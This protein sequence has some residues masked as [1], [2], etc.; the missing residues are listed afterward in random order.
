MTLIFITI[1]LLTID[2]DILLLLIPNLT[3]YIWKISVESL[4]C[5]IRS[6]GA[7]YDYSEPSDSGLHQQDHQY[8]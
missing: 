7:E 4:D 1:E 2:K 6:E 3:V 5:R 8:E